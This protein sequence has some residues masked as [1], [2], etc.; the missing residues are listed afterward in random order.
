MQICFED[1][2][3][4]KN[5]NK[6]PLWQLKCKQYGSIVTLCSF[7]T[8]SEFLRFCECLSNYIPTNVEND[9]Y[10]KIMYAIFCYK[11]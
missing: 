11:L 2:Y 10:E 5:A 4:T 8:E 9:R 3:V 7:S 6:L 1:C